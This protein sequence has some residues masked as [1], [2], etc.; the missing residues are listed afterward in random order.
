[1]TQ[2]ESVE[3]RLL[4]VRHGESVVTVDQVMGG[5]R[6]CSGLSPLGRRQAQALR[7]RLVT[8]AM[9]IDALWSSTMPRALETA[10]IIGAGI[11]LDPRTHAEL[12]EHRPGDEADGVPFAEFGDRFGLF[13][14]RDEPH[15]P[16]APGGESLAGFHH[17][18]GAALAEVIAAHVGK[19]VL[20][21]CHGGVVDVAMRGLLGL[22][23][24][25]RFALWTLN[26]SITEFRLQSRPGRDGNPPKPVGAGPWT[27]LRYNDAAHL[28]GL[29]DRTPRA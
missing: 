9:P 13:D 11:G 8:E 4:L 3:T 17:R 12:V 25:P 21:S 14:L 18:A 22:G 1:M 24:G 29:P 6:T 7:D 10:Q 2:P 19:T 5:E 23:F 27:L 28:V 15:R 16:I 26:T 20:V